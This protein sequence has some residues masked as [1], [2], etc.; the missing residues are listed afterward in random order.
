MKKAN[1]FFIPSALILILLFCAGNVFAQ[2]PSSG[3]GIISAAQLRQMIDS[4]DPN[5]VIIG[6]INPTAAL[7]PFSPSSRPIEG[8]FLV[9]RGDYSGDNKP[10]A[11]APEVSGF[12]NTR[13]E[14]EALLSRAGVT[15]NSRI[16]VYS[17][18]AMHD[19]ARFVFQLRMLG[20][21][22]N[23]Y[24]LDGGI[25]AWVAGG[26]PTGRATRLSS[27]APQSTFRAPVYTPERYD[28]SMNM[29]IEALRNPNEWVVI[30]TRA[31]EEFAG[32][33]TGSSSGAFGTGRIA[34]AVHVNWTAAV[35]NNL[36]RPVSELQAIYGDHIRGKKVI[37]YCQSGV[38]SAHTQLVLTDVLGAAEVY[39]YDGSWIEWSFGASEASGNRFPQVRPLTEV[40]SDNRRPI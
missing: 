22:N 28:A 16:V 27:V 10:E 30:D 4:G 36:I 15:M 25:N 13:A 12:R 18:D 40:W 7:V 33:R 24:Y 9:W 5:L 2:A 35:N 11:I 14:M 23:T 38:R 26:H 20:L 29:V 8:S 39:N 31:P 34:G 1:R 19:A 6:V 37:V 17:A 3:G 32:Q 21:E